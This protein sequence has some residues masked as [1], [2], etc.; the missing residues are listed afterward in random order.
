MND[1]MPSGRSAA[2][3]LE[4][5][6][7]TTNRKITASLYV[8][9][10]GVVEA[11]EQWHFAHHNEEFLQALYDEVEA[12]DAMLLGR[13][14]YET[15]AAYWPHQSSEV[16]MADQM[17]NTTKYVVSTTL[18]DPEWQNT[19]VIAGD[20]NARLAE[21]K[22][23]PGKNLAVT[24]SATL[25]NGLL[26]DGLLDE[27]TLLLHPVVVGGGASQR[28]FADAADRVPLDLVD[29]QRFATDVLRIKYAKAA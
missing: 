11:P 22:E 29:V 24:G 15:F 25:V 6:T 3:A 4:E 28:L 2:I 12:S 8:T 21:L 1:P 20:V 16:P 27:L 13:R 23:Q 18:T 26:R 19:S 17:N 7:M 14:T 9:L 5:P 10:D